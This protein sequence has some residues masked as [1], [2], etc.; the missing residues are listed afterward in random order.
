MEDYRKI[1][2]EWKEISKKRAS[3]C[4]DEAEKLRLRE[5][6]QYQISD[7]ES[8][9]LKPGEEDQL[10]T[11]RD[12]LLH[13]EQINSRAELCYRAL[14]GGYEGYMRNRAFY[15]RYSCGCF[16]KTVMFFD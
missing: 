4:R 15:F 6:L 13:Q 10:T 16:Q 8:L 9:K 3:L 2:R 1:Y 11:D 5:I 7:I 14:K 12:R